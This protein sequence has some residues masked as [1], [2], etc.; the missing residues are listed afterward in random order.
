VAGIDRTYWDPIRMGLEEYLTV[1][2]LDR[3][4]RGDGGDT[5]PHSIQREFE[6]IAAVGDKLNRPVDVLGNYIGTSCCLEAFHLTENLRRIVLDEL[7][8]YTTIDIQYPVDA[9]TTYNAYLY[10]EGNERR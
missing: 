1:T 2:V 4:V 7:L 5:L 9:L 8:I 6:H 10:E 3:R